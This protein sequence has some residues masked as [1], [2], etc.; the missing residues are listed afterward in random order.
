MDSNATRRSRRLREDIIAA[1]MPCTAA[2]FLFL[3]VVKVKT[4]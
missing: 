3:C 2:H 1:D 4:Q